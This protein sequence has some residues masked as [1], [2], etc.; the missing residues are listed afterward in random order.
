LKDKSSANPAE[1]FT[2]QYCGKSHRNGAKFCPVTGKII[3]TVSKNIPQN[4]TKLYSK[5]QVRKLL[6]NSKAKEDLGTSNLSLANKQERADEKIILNCPNCN[7][8]V[9]FPKSRKPKFCNKCGKSFVPSPEIVQKT[10]KKKSFK[11][12]YP[13]CSTEISLNSY[14]CP[15][16]FKRIRYCFTC[17]SPNNI[18]EEKCISCGA[19]IPLE[20][21]ADWPMF[22][23]N[24]ERTGNSLQSIEPP[25]V[26]RWKYPERKQAEKIIS[27]PIVYKG[28]IYYGSTDQHLHALNQYTGEVV[29]KK[30]TK[31]FILST[32]AIMDGVVYVASCDGRIYAQDAEKGKPLWV[33]PTSTSKLLGKV[34]APLL[35]CSAGLIVAA[36]SGQ[37]LCIDPKTGKRKWNKNFNTTNNQENFDSSESFFGGTSYFEGNI[38][39]TDRTGKITCINAIDGSEIWSF[40]KNEKKASSFVSIPAC[41]AGHCYV[42]D[43][44]GKIY[45]LSYKTRDDNWNF[46]VDLDGVVE[47]SPALGFGKIIIGTQSQYLVALDI[48]TGGE[49]WRVKNEK[50]RLVD[51]IF[52]TPAITLNQ[53]VFVG[54]DSGYIYCRDVKSGEEVWKYKLDSPVRSSPVISDGFLYVTSSGGFLYAFTNR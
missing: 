32:P 24:P 13:T 1:N 48:F 17:K 44:S 23:G 4:Q 31:G 47:G 27:S 3:D 43:R 34:T 46:T 16:C 54:S 49:S 42:P 8:K 19:K 10:A 22:K 37:L 53:L 38:Y 40:P 50:I 2:C 41:A 39:C 30:P 7:Q 36:D 35:A 15:A 9:S 29:W 18:K 52:S 21:P 12:P 11:C 14:F 33:Y 25:L 28:M 5:E 20:D 26:L 45:A 51:A 6:C